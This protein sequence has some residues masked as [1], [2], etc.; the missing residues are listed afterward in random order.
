MKFGRE[1]KVDVNVVLEG[2]LPMF[3][4]TLP[5]LFPVAVDIR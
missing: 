3:T 1:T 4:L 2:H 5:F